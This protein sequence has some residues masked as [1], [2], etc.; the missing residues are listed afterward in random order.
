[1]PGGRAPEAHPPS[2]P[3]Q[4]R[5]ATRTT[6]T[7]GDATKR[8]APRNDPKHGGRAAAPSGD[9]G[10]QRRQGALRARAHTHSE[11]TDGG[12]ARQGARRRAPNQ[13]SLVVSM[14]S[15]DPDSPVEVYVL[16]GLRSVG[17]AA[18]GVHRKGGGTGELSRIMNACFNELVRDHVWDTSIY[19]TAV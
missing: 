6:G 3:R 17:E 11:E 9:R 18:R 5:G 2:K 4:W 15:S 12:V 16:R 10:H 13:D 7:P 1:M 19:T 14:S 8:V